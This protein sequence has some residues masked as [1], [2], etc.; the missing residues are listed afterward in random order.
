M[1]PATQSNFQRRVERLYGRAEVQPNVSRVFCI[2]LNCSDNLILVQRLYAKLQEMLP[3]A[4]VYLIVFIDNQRAQGAV[5]VPGADK[6]L[7]FWVHEGMFLENGKTWTEQRHCEEYPN[8]IACA[9]RHW[10]RVEAKPE[11]I[12][13]VTDLRS[14]ADLCDPFD[15]GP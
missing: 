12:P 14:L 6:I 5:K 10:A 4:E 3:K 13:M 1:D 9:V 2:A 15:G 7:F 8:G 11:T